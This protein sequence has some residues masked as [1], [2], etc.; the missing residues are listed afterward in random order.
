MKK[1]FYLLAVLIPFLAIAQDKHD[2]FIQFNADRFSSKVSLD[3]LFS[4]KAFK[5]FNKE[6]SK[7]KL[8]DF[9]SFIDDSKKMVIHGN[10]TDSISYY[11]ITLPLTSTVK[12]EEYINE[13]IEKQND[14]IE[15]DSLKE[16]IKRFEN[17][18]SYKSTHSNY[19]LAWNG[20]NLVIYEILSIKDETITQDYAYNESYNND[21]TEDYVYNEEES[22]LIIE[23]LPPPP[24]VSESEY[25]EEEYVV[26]A[27]EEESEEVDFDYFENLKTEYAKE[28][29]LT[30]LKK[31]IQ[32]EYNIDLLFKDGFKFPTSN[33]INV[34]AD[35]SCWLNYGSTFSNL[36]SLSYL[37]K[38][39]ARLNNTLIEQKPVEHAIKGLNADFYFENDKAR[40]EQTIEYST[41]LANIMNKVVDRKINKN[42]FNYFPK[43]TPLG[44]MSYHINTKEILN[45][46]PEISEQMLSS[47]PLES[48]DK[49][50]MIDLMTTIIDE[51][52]IS[53]IYD[54]DFSMFLHNIEKYEDTVTT[55]SYDENYDEVIE[56]KV[57]NKSRP[58]FTF[59][60]T[61]THPTLGDK[62]LKLGIRKGYLIE[63]N[64]YFEIT[65]STPVGNLK[66]IKDKDVIV[67]TNGIDYLNKGKTSDFSKSVKKNLK[68]NYLHGNLFIGQLIDLFSDEITSEK[69]KKAMLEFK[70]QFN[71]FDFKSS[72][73]LKHNKM[74]FEMNLNSNTS[75]KN[76]ILQTLD[77]IEYL[78]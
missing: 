78:D 76:I 53:T 31:S 67:V 20:E 21:Y 1:F 55:Y 44:Y 36:N 26:E 59:I 41:P 69:E 56:E 22:E 33:K 65:E 25:Y 75:D 4:H 18:S 62:L 52:A 45:K 6:S 60:F 72:K 38:S 39:V 70:K 63:N 8:S 14:F 42:I 43:N 58:V 11:Q 77:L 73:S 19:S 10:F 24:P 61:S 74:K 46:Y 23:K 28:K 27:T 68:K 29:Q 50:L 13:N 57:V 71:S 48:E 34:K 12:L 66:I 40:L 5:E 17:Y 16:S 15:I 51:D 3:E 7:L 35:I 54:G 64:D 30:D 49:G 9:T 47:I 37:F 32:Q 2:Y